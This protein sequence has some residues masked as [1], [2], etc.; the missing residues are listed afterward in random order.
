[1]ETIWVVKVEDSELNGY[2]LAYN[3][4]EDAFKKFKELEM[5]IEF[6]FVEWF[7]KSSFTKHSGDYDANKFSEFQ[8]TELYAKKIETFQMEVR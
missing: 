8:N 3:K 5:N 6:D 2:V 1:M 4:K 7:G